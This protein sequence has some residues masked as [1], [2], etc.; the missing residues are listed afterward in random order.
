[1][2]YNAYLT[3]SAS[4]SWS[5][6]IENAS[7]RIHQRDGSIQFK[8]VASGAAGSAITWSESMRIDSSG[9]LLVGTTDTS[10]WNDNSDEYGHNI[11]AHG[12]YYSSTN[13]EINAYLNRQNSDG[14][15]IAFAKD[16]SLVGSID[17]L[18]GTGGA[19]QGRLRV[20]SI[21]TK[22]VFDDNNDLIYPQQDGVTTLGDP[23]AR[24]KNLYLSG[25]VVFGTTGGTVDSKTLDDYEEGSWTPSMSGM[26]NASFSQQFGRYTKI[27][28]LAHV[29]GKIAWTGAD[30][31]AQVSITGLPFTATNTS[32]DQLR[33]SAWPQGD[34]RNIN[35]LIQRNGHFRV[36]NATLFGVID[37]TSGYTAGLTRSEMETFGEFNFYLVYKT[38]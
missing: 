17:S 6:I 4:D 20:G 2:S 1:L 12:Q 11:L 36:S 34:Y 32:D 37:N 27:G 5:R 35:T 18:G 21:D 38:T 13:G 8:Y 31:T 25:G 10:L 29:T 7:T 23:G 26:G 33:N 24:F 22:L 19:S 28:D 16:G 14:T 30:G 3:T 9:N 15:I